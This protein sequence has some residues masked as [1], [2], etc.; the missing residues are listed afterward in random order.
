MAAALTALIGLSASTAIGAFVSAQQDDLAQKMGIAR[1]AL[2]AN[3]NSDLAA[4]RALEQRKYQIAPAVI[5]IEQ[6]SRILPDDT[7][8]TALSI[9]GDKVRISGIAR[10]APALVSV[11][12]RSTRFTRATFFAP[13]TRT[14]GE[15]G[16][17]F[18]IEAVIQPINSDAV[19]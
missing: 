14:A 15:P 10:N 9:E 16:E 18:H 8:L 12:E 6:L 2:A 7:F 5:V 11:L 3:T 19:L 17:R 1:N 13:S 4:Q